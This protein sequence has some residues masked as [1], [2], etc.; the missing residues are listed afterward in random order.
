M[1]E[2]ARGGASVVRLKS[3]DPLIFGRAGEEIEAL[4]QAQVPCEVVPGVTTM[5]AA[6]AAAKKSLTDRRSAS[7]VILTTA[8]HASHSDGAERP[9]F[10]RGP[11]PNDATLGIYMPG[12]RSSRACVGHAAGRVA[13]RFADRR[14]EPRFASG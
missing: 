3:G 8:H 7:K 12:T 1:I 14:D 13:G 4:E 6:A 2:K 5:F 10:W 9:S 11:L